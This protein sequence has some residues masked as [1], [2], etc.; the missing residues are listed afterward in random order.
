MLHLAL[1]ML[2]GC[3]GLMLG[4]RLAHVDVIVA[5]NWVCHAHV[6]VA[7]TCLRQHQIPWSR[8]SAWHTHTVSIKHGH[9]HLR[10]THTVS[11]T[12]HI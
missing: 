4:L 2:H 8:T 9:I 3:E 5:L 7:R 1:C 10:G 11:M 6:A 12:R